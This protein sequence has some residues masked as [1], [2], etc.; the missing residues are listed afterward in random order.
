M[1]SKDKVAII[2][3]DISIKD[4]YSLKLKR[5][6]YDVRA[7]TDG[8]SGLKLIKEFLPDLI[9]LDLMMPVMTGDEMLEKMR[10][11]D[12]AKNIR[13]IVLTN[14]SKDEITTK[15]KPLDVD[16]YIVKADYTPKQIVELVKEVLA[17]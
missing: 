16:R 17:S 12:W 7:A 14:I 1:N 3:D 10:T 6:G 9:M 11:H 5:E 4:L 15:L 8:V 2:E 13:V